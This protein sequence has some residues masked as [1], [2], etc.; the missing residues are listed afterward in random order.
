MEGPPPP[1]MAATNDEPSTTN[2]SKKGSR[3]IRTGTRIDLAFPTVIITPSSKRRR[4]KQWWQYRFLAVIAL[5]MTVIFRFF[6]RTMLPLPTGDK[7]LDLSRVKGIEN[8][9]VD[10]IDSWCLTVS[11]SSPVSDDCKVYHSILKDNI[12]CLFFTGCCL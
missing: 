4:K 9:S 1:A 5:C 12:I 3:R 10:A 7:H 2:H 6:K 11:Y 8:L